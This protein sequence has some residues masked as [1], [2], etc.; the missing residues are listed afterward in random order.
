[1][2]QYLRRALTPAVRTQIYKLL[3]DAAELLATRD[4][5]NSIVDWLENATT[6]T[7]NN[8]S[9]LSGL[10]QSMSD[11]AVAFVGS[12]KDYFRLDRYSELTPDSITVVSAT[13][14]GNWIRFE[15]TRDRSWSYQP[16][17]RIDPNNGNDENIGSASSPL[18]SWAE[19]YRRVNT[20]AVSMT[21][22]I[23]DDLSESI[24]GE[25]FGA[26]TGLDLT[27]EGA[28]TTIIDAGAVTT[29]TNPV[30]SSPSSMGTMTS[31]V[32]ANFTPYIGK[33]LVSASG[34]FTPILGATGGG[35]PQLGFW[36]NG[37]FTSDKPTNGTQVSIV[38]L[39]NVPT[40]QL[41]MHGVGVWVKFL[42]ATSQNYGDGFC[43]N[44]DAVTA[45]SGGYYAVGCEIQGYL[46]LVTDVW[47]MGCYITSQ[48]GYVLNYHQSMFVSGG[49]R[50]TTWQ[51]RSGGQ[52]QFAGF[53][54]NRGGVEVGWTDHQSPLSS[55]G[56]WTE[57]RGLGIFNSP[58]NGLT[59]ASTGS[60]TGKVIYGNGNTGYGM[61]V[62]PG[63]KVIVLFAPNITGT[64][65][66][67]RFDGSN[68]AIPPLTAGAAVP[69]TSALATW[70]Q[71]AAAPFNSKVLSYKNGAVLALGT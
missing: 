61:E 52:V 60:V 7:V 65:G 4:T 12:V 26:T 42:R 44:G 56:V 67:L 38:E 25:F 34:F 66:D 53:I 11:G 3:G 37:N 39:V 32:V 31:G 17:W 70:A 57:N 27:I 43:I 51:L 71:W 20:L 50:D 69:N 5:I 24:I 33:F 36:D 1:M 19:F 13:G 55:I 22:T 63:G 62:L 46:C 54:V 68:V 59:V 28:Y 10:Q 48:P 23:A 40:V 2:L 14:G 9:E 35:E 18:A 29:F 47:Y 15:S 58:G 64:S 16:T 21:V 41:T 8:I 6:L 30:T 45:G 49:S